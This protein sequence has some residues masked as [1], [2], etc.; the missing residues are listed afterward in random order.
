M[1]VGYLCGYD[2][3]FSRRNARRDRASAVVLQER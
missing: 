2:F 3:G 1:F